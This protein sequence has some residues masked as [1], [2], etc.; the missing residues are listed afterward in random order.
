MDTQ[1]TNGIH[2]KYRRKHNGKGVV[3][4]HFIISVYLIIFRERE[5][6]RETGGFSGFSGFLH[7]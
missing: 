3:E 5:R 7:Q 6:E 1:N 2:F 4:M